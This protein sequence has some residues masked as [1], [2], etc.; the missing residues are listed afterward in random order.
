MNPRQVSNFLNIR[1]ASKT[2]AFNDR[3]LNARKF[4]KVKPWIASIYKLK[5]YWFNLWDRQYCSGLV[6]VIWSHSKIY[7]L[8]DTTQSGVKLLLR[9]FHEPALISK[10]LLS[11]VT[12]CT[13]GMGRAYVDEL[14]RR[15]MD[16]VLVGRSLSALK[17]IAA[18][19]GKYQG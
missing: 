7:L 14:A 11:V 9:C 15:K 3:N 13:R 16:I 5:V 18:E 17:T 1:L 12:G 8:F 6:Y 19:V 10:F 2:R 4:L